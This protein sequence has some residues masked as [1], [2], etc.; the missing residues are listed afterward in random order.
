M[1]NRK[2]L[3]VLVFAVLSSA[4]PAPAGS[5]A[6]ELK[7][8]YD[9]RLALKSSRLSDAD[10]TLFKSKILPAAKNEWREREGAQDCLPGSEPVAIDVAQ[11]AFT[12]PD[13]RQK[14]I[15]YRFCETGHNMALNGIAVIEDD[16]VISHLA[17]EGEWDNAIGALPDINGNGRSEILIASGGTNQGVTW[18]AVRIIELSDTIVLTKFG[19]TRTYSD[20]RGADENNG[21]ARAYRLSAQTGK[22]TVFFRE[23]FIDTRIGEGSGAWKETGSLKRISLENDETDYEFVR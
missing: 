8:I 1:K 19:R 18:G 16:R 20:N 2:W 5:R 13:V 23:A 21:K 12:R 10:D 15:L 9:A 11:G 14:A 7:T 6:Q 3:M 17:Y 22:D 4:L